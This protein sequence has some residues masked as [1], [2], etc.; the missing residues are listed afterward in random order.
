MAPIKAQSPIAKAL[1]RCRA[2]SAKALIFGMTIRGR[3]FIA[4]MAMS[5]ITVTLGG[6]AILGIRHAGDLVN[7]T[8]DESLMSINYARA[9]ATDFAAIRAAFARL[10]ITPDAALREKLKSDIKTLKKNFEDDLQIAVQRS[11]SDRARKAAIRLQSAVE[12]WEDMSGRLL[13]LEPQVSW[14]DLDN[15]ARKIDEQIELL[16][17][18]TAGDGFLYRQSARATVSRELKINIFGTALAILLLAL[19]SW[20]LAETH[21]R[22]GCGCIERS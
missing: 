9:A 10:Q 13:K 11:Q 5:I 2:S 7:K 8:Y 12:T 1:A 19:I 22:S 15:Y 21:C 18:Y 3:I 6:N 14:S 4:F 16:V 17:N 20:A